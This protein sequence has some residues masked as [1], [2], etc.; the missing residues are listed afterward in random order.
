MDDGTRTGVDIL[1]HAVQVDLVDELIGP[2]V[3]VHVEVLRSSALSIA[4][5][6]TFV[7]WSSEDVLAAGKCRKILSVL[8]AGPEN[9]QVRVCFMDGVSSL[10]HI[11]NEG[12]PVVV[13]VCD[14]PRLAQFVTQRHAD[15]VGVSLSPVRNVGETTTPI[16]CIKVEVIKPGGSINVRAAPL[17][18]ASMHVR[19]DEDTL[20]GGNACNI[21]P[22]LE[23]SRLR[24]PAGVFGNDLVGDFCS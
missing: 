14:I 4:D 9:E 7:A 13:Q 1:A 10:G 2:R 15:D 12:L 3:I 22:N 16:R 17:R 24:C 19:L 6:G 8:H 20:R 18:L 5:G 21:A 23:A 11:S